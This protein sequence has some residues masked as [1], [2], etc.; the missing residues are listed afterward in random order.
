MKVTLKE[1]QYLNGLKSI[2]IF[3]PSAWDT[4]DLDITNDFEKIYEIGNGLVIYGFSI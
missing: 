3:R 1:F 2:G 4:L